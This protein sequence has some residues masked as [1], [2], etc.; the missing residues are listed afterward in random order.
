MKV[1][2]FEYITGGGFA[3][4]D[5]PESLAREGLLMLETLLGELAELTSLQLT[6]LLDYRIS[7]AEIAEKIKIIS[8]TQK[9]SVYELLPE[10]IEASDWVWPIAPEMNSELQ[11]IS[12]LVET[13][14][15][16][17]LNSSL[18]AVTLCSDK[19]LTYQ[20]LKNKG[21]TVVD[22][23]ALND[24]VPQFP[25][26]WVVKPK[27]GMGCVNTH[28]ISKKAALEKLES[29]IEKKADYI[30]Q[31]YVK[32]ESLSLSC[33]FKDGVGYLLCCNRQ[34]IL[35]EQG[36]F[37]LIACEVN[38][39]TEKLAIYQNLADQV[40]DVI[41]GLWGYAGI[42]I[43]QSK[44]DGALILE[45][46]PRLTTSYAGIHRATGVNVAKAVV[47]MIEKEPQIDETQNKTIIVSV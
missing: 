2:V 31:P 40:A 14:N 6:V 35:H 19:L 18:D 43:I 46:N 8:V 45:I 9:Q 21:I 1:L 34:Q 44:K 17:L 27:D 30:F 23:H 28:L 38:I 29:Q 10:L 47:D 32:G 41:T 25:G 33:L 4:E 15:K 7:L 39:A 26:K 37:K 24:I 5:L 13:K 36:E 42:D 16:R 22:T 20:R 3:Q 12:E 11:K